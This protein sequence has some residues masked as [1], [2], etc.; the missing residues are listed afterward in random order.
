VLSELLRVENVGEPGVKQT[1]AVGES[2][3][4]R[5]NGDV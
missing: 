3:R 5:F 2:L 1:L 4:F